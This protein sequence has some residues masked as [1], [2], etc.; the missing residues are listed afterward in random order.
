MTVELIQNQ[1]KKFC[2]FSDNKQLTKTYNKNKKNHRET[3]YKI[4]YFKHM[5]LAD[6]EKK[7][8]YLTYAKKLDSNTQFNT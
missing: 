3:Q 7:L 2:S 4:N 1:L 5:T 8:I 6:Q